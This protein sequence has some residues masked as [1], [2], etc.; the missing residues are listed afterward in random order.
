M[1]FGLAFSN[2]G[3]FV[4]PGQAVQLAHAAEDAGFESVWTVDHVVIPAG[5]RSRYPYDPSGRLGPDDTVFPDPLIWLTYIA[6][7]T[8][9]LRLG[10]A[11]LILPQR[12]PVVLAK[13]LATLDH[14]SGGRVI[15]GVGVGWLKEEYEALGVPWEGR[16]RRGEESIG[17]MRA[18]WS[19]E[20][21][22]YHGGTTSFTD[23]FLRPQPT[24]GTIPIHIGGHSLTAARRAG[25]LGDGFFPFGVGRHDVP[26]LLDVVSQAA[27]DAGR[28]PSAIEVTMDS[29]V[30]SGEEARADVA[31]LKAL[32]AARVLVPAGM[33]GIDPAPALRRYAEEVM[34]QV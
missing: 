33:F 13:E 15:L 34:A 23:C 7:A 28:D 5:Y 26:P 27:R 12:N 32:G 8:S 19:D 2:I 9:T 18:L 10:T 11:I 22:T 25:R 1:K 20:R 14:L 17:A 6:A 3:S 16:G 21:A 31:A 24:E 4:G 30:T 29:F